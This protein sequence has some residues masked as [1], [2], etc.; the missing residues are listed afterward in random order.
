MSSINKTTKN[1]EAELLKVLELKKI[2]LQNVAQSCYNIKN[3]FQKSADGFKKKNIDI[4]TN[5]DV[6]I[7]ELQ[8]EDVDKT[9]L[10]L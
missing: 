3:L 6:I 9:I 1:K 5:Q 2:K 7:N 8:N 4:P 10:I